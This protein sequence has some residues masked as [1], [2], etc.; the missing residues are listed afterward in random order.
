MV[1][2]DDILIYSR[3]WGEHLQ[4]LHT[5]F[6]T[7]KEHKLYAKLSKC[8]FGQIEIEYLGHIIN[9]KGVSAEEGKVSTKL[10]WPQPKTLKALRGFLGLTGY[11]RRFVKDY[12]K[13]S[14]P[15]TDLL[16]KDSF[17]WTIK[18]AHAFQQ[19]KGAMSTTTVLTLPDY[20]KTFTVECD[21][22]GRGVG[23]VLQ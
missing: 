4:H 19:L 11:Y 18:A 22:S 14:K 21:A 8:A 5:T 16:K 2:F 23:A 13:M 20:T 3:T 17:I 12:G 6:Q 10:A 15:L 7:L 9:E 1:F